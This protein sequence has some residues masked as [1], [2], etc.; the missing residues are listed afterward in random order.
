MHFG[1]ISTPPTG[2]LFLFT[3]LMW[4][5]CGSIEPEGPLDED[6]DP[7]PMPGAFDDWLGITA[8]SPVDEIG[9]RPTIE[10]EFNAYLDPDTFGSTTIQLRSGGFGYG[11]RTDYYMTRRTLRFRP[12]FSLEPDLTYTLRIAGADGIR[13]VTDSPIS[14]ATVL[15]ELRS[16]DDIADS[17]PLER[18]IVT[19]AEVEE[20]FD[21]H[22]NDCHGESSRNLHPL[23]SLDK[24]R[25]VGQRSEQVDALLVQPFQPA[26]SYLM[27]KILPD[28]PVRRFTVQPPPWSG[29][30]PLS[31]EDIERIEHWIANGARR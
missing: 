25:L 18:P 20:I 21:A 12:N 22:C 15:P 17:E 5:G 29:Q 6:G 7:I 13:S 10:V 27:H 16:R 19:W 4:M 1:I 26:R 31:T 23:I 28:Y 11:G 24:D 3:L 30:D 14:P 9:L 8:I 2:V